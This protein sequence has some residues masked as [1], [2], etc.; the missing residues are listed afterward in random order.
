MKL[1]SYLKIGRDEDEER[2]S[3]ER[4]KGLPC[5][6]RNLPPRPK[7]LYAKERGILGD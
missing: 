2:D 4:I 7:K 6:H 3:E 1:Q 5:N